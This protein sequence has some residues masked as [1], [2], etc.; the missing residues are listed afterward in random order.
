MDFWIL[1]V[2]STVEVNGKDVAFD[3]CNTYYELHDAIRDAK[4]LVDNDDVIQVSVH[5]WILCE[6]GT[7]MHA[8]NGDKTDVPFNF[9]NKNH[10]E[11]KKEN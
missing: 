7:Q 2:L 5:H 10:R 9:V 4:L 1:D 8:D 6:D 11:M 3:Y